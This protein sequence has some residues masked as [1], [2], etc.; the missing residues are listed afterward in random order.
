MA[1]DVREEQTFFSLTRLLTFTA[2]PCGHDENNSLPVVCNCGKPECDSQAVEAVLEAVF[3]VSLP[4]EKIYGLQKDS[5]MITPPDIG[6]FP[7]R[8]DQAYALNPAHEDFTWES[9]GK[10]LNARSRSIKA[11]NHGELQENTIPVY[12]SVTQ[13]ISTQLSLC[14]RPTFLK[15]H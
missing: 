6:C 3:Q 1:A 10:N 7:I 13:T 14:D 12:Q 9:Q 8:R 11:L 15:P 4:P 5:V 2:L